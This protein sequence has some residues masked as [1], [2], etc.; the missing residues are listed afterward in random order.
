MVKGSKEIRCV[1][2]RTDVGCAIWWMV[3]RQW[4]F[5]SLFARYSD[6]AA[7]AQ[8]KYD[9]LSASGWTPSGGSRFT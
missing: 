4:L 7:E 3:N 1:I 5:R 6:A 8:L 9:D 2:E